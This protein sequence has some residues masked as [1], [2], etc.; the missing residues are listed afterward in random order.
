[1]GSK[2]QERKAGEQAGPGTGGGR[3]IRRHEKSGRV[4]RYERVR[5]HVRV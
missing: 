1:M 5:A 2:G 3:G 4:W